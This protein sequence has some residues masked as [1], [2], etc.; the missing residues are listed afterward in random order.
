MTSKPEDTAIARQRGFG[1]RRWPPFSIYV[2]LV[3]FV[4]AL[5]LPILGFSIFIIGRYNASER[6][7]AEQRALALSSTLVTQMDLEIAANLSLLETLAASSS[8]RE[9]NLEAFYREVSQA[10]ERTGSYFL[11]T[12]R[13]GGL[14]LNTRG[15]SATD[16]PNSRDSAGIAEVVAIARPHISGLFMGPVSERLVYNIEV[17]VKVGETIPYVLIMAPEIEPLSRLLRQELLPSGWNGSIWDGEGRIVARTE[18][19]GRRRIG[20]KVPA[21]TAA[22]AMEARGM[23]VAVD[24]HG[25]PSVFAYSTSQLSKWRGVVR[26]PVE[27]LEAPLQS[28]RFWVAI[29]G[30]SAAGLAILLAVMFGNGVAAAIG[31]AAEA[32][33]STARG[34]RPDPVSTSVKEVNEVIGVL[35]ATSQKLHEHERHLE[36]TLRE[37]Q[38]RTKNIMAVV[39]AMARQTG[40]TSSSMHEFHT[41]F[42]NR[43]LAISTCHDILVREDWHGA[44]ILELVKGQLA[45]FATGDP[46][47]LSIA[48][49]ELTLTPEAAEQM[50]LALHEL[51]T[52]ATKYGAWSV[53]DG[54]VAI[55]WKIERDAGGA[56]QFRFRWGERGGPAV[57]APTRDGFG[58]F[59]LQRCVPETLSGKSTHDFARDGIVWELT[60]PFDRIADTTDITI[61]DLNVATTEAPPVSVLTPAPKIVRQPDGTLTDEYIHSVRM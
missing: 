35:H 33:R 11:M 32:A 2:H 54:S 16:L 49:A 18:A 44:S 42:E 17:P 24:L 34:S 7:A 47:A 23:F 45:P 15:P 40:R 51:G 20:D 58:Q 30:G 43:L 27:I 12:D 57:R 38:H 31:T 59:V 53:P 46:D 8:L 1:A 9:G 60:A 13:R 29:A 39:L 3:L 41:A 5:L 14:V 25:T 10:T 52:N 48:G 4:I 56:A 6:A 55:E 22:R 37:L 26:V 21:E 50:S 36:F 19:D 61:D 28:S